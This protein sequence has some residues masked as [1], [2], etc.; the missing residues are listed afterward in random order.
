MLKQSLTC[1]F[2][3]TFSLLA[4]FGTAPA[5]SQAQSAASV[6]E[7]AK[8]KM[9]EMYSGIDHVMVKTDTFTS[10]NR[11][12]RKDGEVEMQT[13]IESMPGA[14]SDSP[15]GNSISNPLAQM[16]ALA[17]HGTYQG[18]KTIAGVECHVIFLDDPSKVDAQFSNGE[19]VSYYIGVS[20]HLIHGMDMSMEDGKSMEMRMFDYQDYQGIQYPDRMEMTMGQMDE[21]SKQQMENLKEQLKQIPESMRDQMKKQLE[22]AMGMIAGEPMVV[23]TEEV[24]V[25]GP[26]PAGIFDQ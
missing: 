25:N 16:D 10:Y 9:I 21:A 11:L 23:K 7:D 3:F 6:V 24:V 20:D 4:L 12:I 2:L 14:G 8:S 26:L 17:E 19:S 22:Q 5:V 13:Q 15:M 18:T 1:R